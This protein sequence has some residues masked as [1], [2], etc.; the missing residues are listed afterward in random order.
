M[1]VQWQ[2]YK[3]L[4][5]LPDSVS[6]SEIPLVH[7]LFPFI[8]IWRVLLNALSR[9][10]IYEN[11]TEYLERC[12]VLSDSYLSHSTYRNTLHQLLVLMDLDPE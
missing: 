5:L 12:W 6:K 9:E 10:H 3:E 4:E 1:N 2:R 7:L 8:A 11:R